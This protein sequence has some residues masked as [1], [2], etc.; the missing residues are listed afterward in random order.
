MTRTLHLILFFILF[1]F[2]LPL[3][4]SCHPTPYCLTL[5]SSPT[6]AINVSWTP[7]RAA[8]LEQFWTPHN[9]SDSSVALEVRIE[10]WQPR[11]LEVSWT[12]YYFVPTINPP[13]IFRDIAWPILG[14]GFT[15]FISLYFILFL[16]ILLVWGC[17]RTSSFSPWTLGSLKLVFPLPTLTSESSTMLVISEYLVH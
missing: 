13:F 5:K 6:L 12:T 3:P 16:Y 10:R 4:S 11:N 14:A 7:W 8:L 1:Y 15:L 17:P 2:L 9:Y